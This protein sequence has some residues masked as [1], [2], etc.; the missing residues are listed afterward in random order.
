MMHAILKKIIA[1]LFSSIFLVHLVAS[2]VFADGMIMPPPDYWVYQSEQ[3]A[4][5]YFQN[6]VETLV[7]S[8]KFQGDAK[9][10]AW[11][12]PVP[13]KPSV[14]KA[15]EDLFE[16]LE[17]LTSSFLSRSGIK[18]QLYTGLSEEENP[19]AV[20][21]WETK[22]ID[23][24]E[25]SV[26]SSTSSRALQKWLENN[27]YAY[28]KTYEYLLR[29]YIDDGWFFVAV[30]IDTSVEPTIASQKLKSGHAAPLKLTFNTTQPI[31]PMKISQVTYSPAPTPPPT[32]PHP[33]P[34][35][36]CPTRLSPP[37]GPSSP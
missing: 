14:E 4:V 32:P 30:K 25:T 2:P 24:Y 12:I 34:S 16:N 10:F 23:I 9:D 8:I 1:L 17:E 33:Y 27:H 3:K 11:I 15:R 28:P 19:T 20:T 18:K 29:E 21:V 31:Y 37:S 7:L 36:L 22:K 13:A 26:L 35:P 5:V 6:D